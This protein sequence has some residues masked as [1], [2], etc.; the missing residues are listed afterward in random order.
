M[1][2][3]LGVL[4]LIAI[5]VLT[6]LIAVL[7]IVMVKRDTK[8][9]T[10]G[11]LSSAMVH[12]QSL[13]QPGKARPVESSPRARGWR[14]RE[15]GRWVEWGGRVGADTVCDLEITTSRVAAMS[16]HGMARELGAALGRELR[17][18]PK[19]DDSNEWVRGLW[20]DTPKQGSVAIR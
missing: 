7:L 3:L 2:L 4:A 13:F 20:D 8:H 15:G 1:H 17:S 11:S 18:S 6:T 16:R 5:V 14:L 10:S 19:S 9:G 12:V